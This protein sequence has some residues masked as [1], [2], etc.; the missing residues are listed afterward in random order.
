ML[1]PCVQDVPPV[2]AAFRPLR[3]QF[4]EQVGEQVVPRVQE[5]GEQGPPG[6][7]AGEEFRM[8][9]TERLAELGK[10]DSRG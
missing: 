9:F 1:A 2:R 3:V 10:E 4:D 5:Q 8:S 7:D 6:A